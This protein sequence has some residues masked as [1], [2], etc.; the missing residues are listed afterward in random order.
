MERLYFRFV[1]LLNLNHAKYQ[2]YINKT[3]D[4]HNL[5]ID[6][7]NLVTW[8][9]MIIFQQ[10]FKELYHIYSIV[11]ICN[12]NLST[13][14]TKKNKSNLI[15][16]RQYLYYEQR[17]CLDYE[18]I[19]IKCIIQEY[20]EWSHCDCGQNRIWSLWIMKLSMIYVILR[21]NG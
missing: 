6:I 19:R 9:I 15:F 4:K 20:W 10:Y 17:N 8:K 16:L 21:W 1:K 11:E 2:E 7:L 5:L 14:T 18:M 3:Y 13:S 12:M